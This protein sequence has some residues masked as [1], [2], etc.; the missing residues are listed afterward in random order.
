MFEKNFNAERSLKKWA[1]ILRVSGFCLMGICFL[2]AL[3]VLCIDADWLWW[4]SLTILGGG[5]L[6]LLVTA[7]FSSLIWG[8]GDVVGNTRRMTSGTALLT[9]KNN[10]KLPDL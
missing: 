10:D 8:F 2:A 4:I 3:I 5:G 6:I 7:L 9:E 1:T